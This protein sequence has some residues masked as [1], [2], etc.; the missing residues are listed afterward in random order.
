MHERAEV[1][2]VDDVIAIV[3]ELVTL[4]SLHKIEA[5]GAANLAEALDRLLQRPQIAVIACD[6]RLSR[7]SGLDIIP[8]IQKHAELRSR[9]FRYLFMSGD[10]MQIQQFP[11]NSG[12]QVLTKPIHPGTLIRAVTDMLDAS[13]LQNGLASDA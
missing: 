5:H 11:A 2:V 3:E 7:E 8:L 6:V 12:Y 9:S 1:L 10:P 13:V 4:L